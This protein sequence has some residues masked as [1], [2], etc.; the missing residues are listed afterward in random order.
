[1]AGWVKQVQ[2]RFAVFDGDLKSERERSAMGDAMAEVFDVSLIARGQSVRSEMP[3]YLVRGARMV[4]QIGEAG[5]IESALDQPR[6]DGQH[7]QNCYD[8]GHDCPLYSRAP[9][10]SRREFTLVNFREALGHRL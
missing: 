8:S 2:S 9:G 1:M 4:A 10:R 3:V 6:H 7:H 5:D